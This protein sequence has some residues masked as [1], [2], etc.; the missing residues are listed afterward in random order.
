MKKGPVI[1]IGALI[2]FPAAFALWMGWRA[3]ESDRAGARDTVARAYRARLSDLA[4]GIVDFVNSSQADFLDLT[5]AAKDD[6]SFLSA[7]SRKNGLVRQAF[8][9]ASGE[10]AYPPKVGGTVEESAFVERTRDLFSEGALDRPVGPE[11][12]QIA[13]EAGWRSWFQ[14]GG[15][16]F[17]F[18]R[19]TDSGDIVG[20]EL[21]AA[22]FLG[23]LAGAMPDALESAKRGA[24]SQIVLVDA[25]GKDF[26]AWGRY[27]RDK[28]EKPLASLSLEDPFLG[29]EF[30]CYADPGS[31]PALAAPEFW[32]LALACIVLVAFTGGAISY[33]SRGL[34]RELAEARQ[35]VSFVN[36]VSHE[37]KTPLTNIRLYVD[38]FRE[39]LGGMDG[40][41][42]RGGKASGPGGEE[43]RDYLDVISSESE[44]L[45]RL[46]HNVLSFARKE[47]REA[48]KPRKVDW[49][50]TVASSMA[51]FMP[52]FREKGIELRLVPGGGGSARV[53]P[54]WAGQIIGNLVSNA[55]KY[56]ASGGAVEV[57]SG[58]EAGRVWARV[59]DFGPGIP[60]ADRERIFEPFVRLGDSLTEGVSGSGLGLSISRDLARRHGGDL[61]LE[62]SDSGAC[63]LLTL[64]TEG[65]ADA[66]P[67]R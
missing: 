55:E 63:F 61:I 35:R 5:E 15:Q 49:D 28:D 29:W 58:S 18:W 53:D 51:C 25:R 31:L 62:E 19:K 24:A 41:S 45:S 1:A 3:L 4:S 6:P 9:V 59:R 11:R 14:G 26:L 21:N 66:R 22:A 16:Q 65:G 10:L 44:R 54:D 13:P 23:R 8:Y 2:L 12:N 33:L 40:N 7:I 17:A 46:I 37:L 52:A 38:L 47:K 48:P 20:L 30:Q 56:A 60:R 42:K 39:K 67:D 36:Q 27:A 57:S 64:G 34:R 50:E 32:F 43:F